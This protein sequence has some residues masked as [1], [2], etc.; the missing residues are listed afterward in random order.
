MVMTQLLLLM[1]RIQSVPNAIVSHTDMDN[2]QE[3]TAVVLKGIMD[4]QLDL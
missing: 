1:P 4:V 3:S 2:L